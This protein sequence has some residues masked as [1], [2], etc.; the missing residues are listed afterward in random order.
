[1]KD[2]TL[3]AAPIKQVRLAATGH[4]LPIGSPPVVTCCRAA[5]EQV[6][7]GARWAGP[8]AGAPLGG[9]RAGPGRRGARAGHAALR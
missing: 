1:M 6:E 8:P 9:R 7:P 5:I 4:R 2:Q 3:K